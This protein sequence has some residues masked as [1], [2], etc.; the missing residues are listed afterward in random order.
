MVSA[1]T[2]GCLVAFYPRATPN[3][4]AGGV[5][6]PLQWP[7]GYAYTMT[8]TKDGVAA[9]GMWRNF[10]RKAP[11]IRKSQIHFV[12]LYTGTTTPTDLFWRTS[13]LT[14]PTGTASRLTE[15]A[16]NSAYSANWDYPIPMP[17]PLCAPA[18][19]ARGRAAARGGHARRA[20]EAR[21]SLARSRP[22]WPARDVE[23]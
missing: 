9:F 19:R 22:Q 23:Y 5:G 17:L 12:S 3:E 7:N 8:D 2:T 6:V 4:G 10:W 1:T 14:E 15:N 11:I 13:R 21:A 18:A 20:R 16:L